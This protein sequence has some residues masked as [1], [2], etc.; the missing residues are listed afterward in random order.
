MPS[1]AQGYSW[2]LKK[3]PGIPQ[4]RPLKKSGH[5]NFSHSYFLVSPEGKSGFSSSRAARASP[6]GA[7]GDAHASGRQT[8]RTNLPEKYLQNQGTLQL[9]CEHPFDGRY[10]QPTPRPARIKPRSGA[11]DEFRLYR[12]APGSVPPPQLLSLQPLRTRSNTNSK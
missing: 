5:T 11:I 10:W 3:V 7:P 4:S 1:F 6:R 9:H 12:A 8:Q 2:Q